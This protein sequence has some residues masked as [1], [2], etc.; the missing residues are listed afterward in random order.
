ITLSPTAAG[1][2]WF[3]D[4]TP[5]DNSEFLPTSNP[6][7]WIARPGGGAEGRMDLRTV[8]LHEYGHVVGLEHT[9][10]SHDLMASTLLPGVRRLP[11]S[12][13]LT[14]LRGMLFGA[15]SAPLPYDPF[16]PPGAPLPLSRSLGSLH[17]SRIRPSEPAD[18]SAGS[19]RPGRSQ[20]DTAANLTLENPT[21]TNG[22]GWTTTG[23][24]LFVG[25]S[26]TLK[27]S[28]ATQT[29]LNQAFVI[30]ANDR[31][32]AFNLSGI[33]LDDIDGAPDDAFEVALIDASSGRSLLPGTGLADSDAILNL[34]ADGSE[35]LAAG[36][37]IVGNPDGSRSVL[38]DLA[39]VAAGTVANLSFDLIGFGRG[40]AATSSQVTISQLRL[41]GAVREARDDE[42]TTA[43]DTP[44]TLDLT[45]NDPGASQPGVSPVLVDAPMHGEVTVTADG[46]FTYRP[47]ADWHGDDRFTYRLRGNGV[48][49]NVAVVSLTVT[50]VNDAPTIV[51]RSVTLDEDSEVTLDLLDGASDVDGDALSV[52]TASPRHGTLVGNADGTITYR[53]VADF[54]GEDSFLWTV[55]DGELQT[56]SLLRITINAVNDAPVAADDTATLAEDGHIVLD[57]LD[58][59]RDADGDAL[60]LIVDHPP[61]H[62][63][64]T[65]DAEQRVIY[66]PDADWS[67][68]DAFGYLVD[69]GLA[70]SGVATV[71]LI[72]S[73]LADAP[74]LALIDRAGAAR[75]VFRTGWESVTN[76]DGASTVVKQDQ[77][78]GWRLVNRPPASADGGFEVWSS[79]DLLLNFQGKWRTLSAA[80]GNGRNWLE[81]AYAGG[82]LHPTQAIE[83]SIDTV[84]GA[85]Y[86]VS[87]DLA[88]EPGYSADFARVGIAVDG[89]RIG[90]E[91]STSPLD[92]LA[93]QTRSFQ[94]VG[95]GG[96]QTL[97]IAAEPAR[98]PGRGRGLMIDDITLREAL[99]AGTG[100]EDTA[101]RL[102]AIRGGLLDADGSETLE[103]FIEGLP[104]AATLSDGVHRFTATGNAGGNEEASAAG[105]RITG[106]NLEQLWFTPPPDANGRFALTV[107]ATAIE[108]ATQARASTSA[109]LAIT[110][111]PVNDAPVARD[112]RLTLPAGGRI[113]I[114][115]AALVG[116]VDGD[117][118]T[119]KVGDPGHGTVARNA[120][121]TWRYVPQPRY[122]GAD[123]FT[124]SV[125]DGAL[126]AT[127]TIR[128]T[129]T[130]VND[131]PGRTPPP[132][133]FSAWRAGHAPS[134]R[135]RGDLDLA[136]LEIDGRGVTVASI[137][138]TDCAPAI[139]ADRLAVDE[140]QGG[141]GD[142]GKQRF[143]A[144]STT[145]PDFPASG[146]GRPASLRVLASAALAAGRSSG[147]RQVVSQH[148]GQPTPAATIDWRGTPAA[149]LGGAVIQQNKWLAEFLGVQARQKSRPDLPAWQITIDP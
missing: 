131:Q 117:T 93:W 75:E 84:A 111:L 5:S 104:P 113:D 95:R 78:E 136:A 31:F 110:V 65:R 57:L 64:L 18:S 16:T 124:F 92:G 2:G 74:T 77:L 28:A 32:L 59:D 109:T 105:V 49:S 55:S 144:R 58:N 56:A 120:D 128:L 69:D 112:A 70:G 54:Y 94:F 107:V 11:S 48:D 23:E 138:F 108:Q 123:G 44:I 102:P 66:T 38:I 126:T 36:V 91:A 20:F 106:W 13:E 40:A 76:A 143:A 149:G 45:G 96:P 51:A 41:G 42:A 132:L 14:A 98:Y 72:V 8:L 116:D 68:E 137:P 9:A 83:R 61:A 82:S 121:G 79:G 25:D 88:G 71:R 81:L 146:P 43:E 12:S 4:P 133:A 142:R 85:T 87:L 89:Q 21:F 50:P 118:L 103:M 135:D 100:F 73:P 97:R 63:T 147:E 67:G 141:P 15:D 129:V 145:A 6:L 37:T 3:I 46:S 62:G 125:A 1:H 10:D 47:Q 22:S 33:A 139:D 35:H 101:I 115:L 99:P 60:A 130:P 7:E 127:A 148:G 30:G 90:S 34:Q 29:R 17:S 119:L 52:A 134:I 53:P 114:D 80:A 19:Q 140:G 86:T 27:E 122:S 26:A 39:G 24:V